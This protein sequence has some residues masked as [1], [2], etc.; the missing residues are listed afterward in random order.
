MRKKMKRA[1]KTQQ[2]AATSVEETGEIK[3]ESLR[4]KQLTQLGTWWSIKALGVRSNKGSC[5]Y[6]KSWMK[7]HF[8]KVQT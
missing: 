8:G 2:K 1:C 5:Q 3:L 4:T 7:T 6:V